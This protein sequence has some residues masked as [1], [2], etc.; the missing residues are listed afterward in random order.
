MKIEL[1]KA[2]LV[3]LA[4]S[5]IIPLL[6]F[7]QELPLEPPMPGMVKGTGAHFEITD[8]QYLNVSLQST[9]EITVSLE[10]I[11]KIISINIGPLAA[12]STTLTL[13]GIEPNTSYYKYTEQLPE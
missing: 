1:T 12:T 6:S 3:S 8:S 9:E 5:L 7:A 4:V 11:P 13:S 2:I 10:S